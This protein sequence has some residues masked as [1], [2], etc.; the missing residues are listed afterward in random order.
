MDKDTKSLAECYQPL[1][2]LMSNEYNLILLESEMQDVMEAVDQVR[3]NLNNFTSEFN[4]FR[5]K[6]FKDS[7]RS[8]GLQE[9]M[10]AWENERL[11]KWEN[12]I[13]SP[14][15]NK[16]IKPVFINKK[17]Q[18]A[19]DQHMK[20]F[21]YAYNF[22]FHHRG[23]IE[24]WLNEGEIT[25]KNYNTNQN[26]NKMEKDKYVEGLR[27]GEFE[28]IRGISSY[29]YNYY[30]GFDKD[31]L[32]GQSDDDYTTEWWI[33]YNGQFHYLGESYVHQDDLLHTYSERQS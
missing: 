19:L 26:K 5:D 14:E 22:G 15:Y 21:N 6:L 1:F 9:R 28:R 27:M 25:N 33:I 18:D 30:I 11:K 29:N 23:G 8:E 16:G 12:K 32:F 24:A 4:K 10:D 3:V 31:L 20:E 7:G 17:T 13:F 2:K